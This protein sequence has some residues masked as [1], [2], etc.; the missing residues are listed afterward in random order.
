MELW[1]VVVV[2]LLQGLMSGAGDA[3]FANP[4]LKKKIII[5]VTNIKLKVIKETKLLCQLSDLRFLLTILKEQAKSG[6]AATRKG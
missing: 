1:W 5:L 2:V 6:E 4:Y 3:S